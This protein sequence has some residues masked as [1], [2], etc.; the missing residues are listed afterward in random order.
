MTWLRN[1]LVLGLLCIPFGCGHTAS[2]NLAQNHD[3]QLALETLI[4]ALDA[5]K[6]GKLDTLKKQEKPIRFVDDDQRAGWKLVSFEPPDPKLV[7]LP[8]QDILVA[9][10][11]EKNRDKQHEK[12]VTYQIGVSPVRSVLRS[13][14]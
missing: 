4:T 1:L 10:V 7:I 9:I 5:W 6:A 2:N 11:V 13:D 3:P 14:N 12:T 8:H